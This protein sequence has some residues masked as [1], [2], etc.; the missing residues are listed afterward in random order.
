MT[1]S[2]LLHGIIEWK[3]PNYNRRNP[4]QW[5]ENSELQHIYNY[6]T[7]PFGSPD[8]VECFLLYEIAKNCT[9]DILEFGSWKGRSSCFLAKGIADSNNSSRH[10][11]CIDWFQGDD[12]GGAGA[13]YEDMIRSV[14]FFNL[15]KYVTVYNEDMLTIDYNKLLCDK[16]IDMVFYDS[17][18]SPSPTVSILSSIANLIQSDSIICMHDSMHSMPR[19]AIARLNKFYK[20]LIMLNVWEGFS[21]LQKV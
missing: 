20:E 21:I 4:F 15:T 1:K 13:A 5:L 18:H 12:T 6:T 19:Q 17:D 11:Y 14:Q 8:P 10:L 3:Y 16:K 2:S 9:G 7:G